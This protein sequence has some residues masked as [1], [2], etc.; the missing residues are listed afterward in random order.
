MQKVM[1]AKLNRLNENS[2]DMTLLAETC[3]ACCY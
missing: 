3:T 2:T 1:A